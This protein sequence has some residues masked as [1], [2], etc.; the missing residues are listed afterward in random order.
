MIIVIADQLIITYVL[1]QSLSTIT[2]WSNHNININYAYYILRVNCKG[3][4]STEF[5][6]NSLTL[7]AQYMTSMLLRSVHH[8]NVLKNDS[9]ML[10]FV[11]V[12]HY[13]I[14]YINTVQTLL[15]T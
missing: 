15:T 5:Y 1:Q 3:I 14:V 2:L 4:I 8:V 7:A 12:V 11:Y 13:T 9:I 6:R 10:Q